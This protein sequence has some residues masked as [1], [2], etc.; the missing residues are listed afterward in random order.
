MDLPRYYLMQLAWGVLI[1]R[2]SIQKWKSLNCS[3][4]AGSSYFLNPLCNSLDN[5]QIKTFTEAFKLTVCCCWLRGVWS[6]SGLELAK[7]S[8]GSVRNHTGLALSRRRVASGLTYQRRETLEYDT[9]YRIESC[10]MQSKI[11]HSGKGRKAQWKA[12]CSA[13]LRYKNLMMPEEET[14]TT[15]HLD[16]SVRS[17]IRRCKKCQAANSKLQWVWASWVPG[18][19]PWVWKISRG[20]IS[21]SRLSVWHFSYS[22]RGYAHCWIFQLRV[23]EVGPALLRSFFLARECWAGLQRRPSTIEPGG[24]EGEGFE[25]GLL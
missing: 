16:I 24:L 3:S 8:V 13:P 1:R 19:L 14:P 22:S 9:S 12:I 25:S 17:P 5:H 2:L 15:W 10:A 7:V 21:R 11:P 23:A 4:T 6:W 18:C 20:F